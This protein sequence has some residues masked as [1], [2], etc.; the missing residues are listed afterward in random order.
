MYRTARLHGQV[1]PE[2]FALSRE[3][4]VEAGLHAVRR[5]HGPLEC[6]PDERLLLARGGEAGQSGFGVLAVLLLRLDVDEEELHRVP[7][8]PVAAERARDHF[9]AARSAGHLELD[10]EPEGAEALLERRA[11]E[12]AEHRGGADRRREREMVLRLGLV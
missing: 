8:D 9:C 5:A 3:I 2:A 7:R 12:P 6:A 10:P 4:R 11:A 1:G